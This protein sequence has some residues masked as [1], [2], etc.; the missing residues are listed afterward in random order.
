MLL[1]ASCK[2]KQPVAAASAE[3][4]LEFQSKFFDAQVYKAKGNEQAAYKAFQ[5]CLILQPDNGAVNYEVARIEHTLQSN[6][7]SA[8]EHALKAVA[9]DANN[10]WYH[11]LLGSI[12]RDAGKYAQ[13]IKTFRQV[14]R[15]QPNDPTP[16]YEI[17]NCYLY[18]RKYAE[19][20]KVLDEIEKLEGIN[21]EVSFQ[22]HRLYMEMKDSDK[23]AAELLKLAETFPEEARYWGILAQF[24]QQNGEEE[25]ANN[26]LDKMVKAD[27]DNGQVH[28]QLSEY[29]AAKGD[30][31]NSYAELKKAF[32]TLDLTMD[33]KINVL[34]KFYQLTQVNNEYNTKSYELLE[35][36]L[37]LHPTD[38][39]IYSMYGDFLYKDRQDAKALDMYKEAAK[40]DNSK[41]AIWSQI[42]LI[43]GSLRMFD[44]L[45]ADAS[46]AVELFPG[47]AQFYY[48]KGIAADQLKKYDMAIEAYSVGK[49]LV[50]DN[51]P[52][53]VQFYSAL[54]TAYHAAGEHAK[55]DDAFNYA[56]QLNPRNDLVLNNYAYYLSLRKSN[57]ERA[58]EMSRLSNEL[59]PDNATFEDTYA[60]VLYQKGDYTN[61]LVWIEK[62][63]EHGATGGEVME[64]YGDILFRNG[65]TNAAVEAW[66]KALGQPGVSSQLEQKIKEQRIP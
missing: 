32:E 6:L 16:L 59:S 45:L 1:L 39:K 64:H 48:F 47:Q 38:A 12:Y 15:L 22:K 46:T 56:L 19:A 37:R 43:E 31:A 60:W 17:S 5:D 41:N 13:A 58:A 66:S 42:L 30:D 51:T 34:L 52:L 8:E 53:L 18:E 21:E 4:D 36:T 26:A 9:S 33:Q 25:K 44:A 10:V 50:I 65:K 35:L 57:L 20:V 61:A 27:P 11:Q 28:Y 23:A 14:Q 24:Y 63:I 54:G 49:E 3:K 7:A 62:A 55:S 29:Y 2:S 40:L